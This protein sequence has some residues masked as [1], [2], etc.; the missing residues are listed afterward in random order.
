GKPGKGRIGSRPNGGD[1][2]TRLGMTRLLVA[3][4]ALALLARP[5]SA[6]DPGAHGSH[7]PAAGTG[8]G[9]VKFATSCSPAIQQRFN[10]AVWVLHSFWYEEAVK[11]FS[12]IAD[13]EPSCAMAYWGIAM[14]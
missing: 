14:S 13:T 3:I 6:A 2:M 9:E 8:M 7:G 5:G 10:Q 11:M 1:P 4:G 12:A